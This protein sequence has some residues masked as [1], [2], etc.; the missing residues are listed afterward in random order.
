MGPRMPSRLSA[1][2]L[3][4]LQLLQHVPLWLHSSSAQSLLEWLCSGKQQ[5]DNCL[6]TSNTSMPVDKYFRKISLLEEALVCICFVAGV[7][8]DTL[9]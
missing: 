9:Q 8:V 3:L 1:R 2:V 7:V 4:S 6:N 5:A